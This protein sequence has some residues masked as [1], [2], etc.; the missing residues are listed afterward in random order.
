MRGVKGIIIAAGAAFGFTAQ[1]AAAQ[2][3]SQQS[4]DAKVDEEK[5]LVAALRQLKALRDARVTLENTLGLAPAPK[6]VDDPQGQ[7]RNAS[8]EAPPS[9]TENKSPSFDT[10]L[11]GI[12][13]GAGIAFTYDL[14]KRDRVRSASLVNGIVRV[15]EVDNVRARLVLESH[16]FFLPRSTFLGIKPDDWGIGPFIALQ[17]G[18]SNIIEGIG[19]GLMLGLKRVRS[20]PDSAAGEKASADTTADGSSFNLGIGVF[21][22]LGVQTLGEGIRANQ[23]LPEGETEIRFSKRSQ[24]GFAILSS[25]AF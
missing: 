23:P 16:Y 18:S 20:N 24:S 2:G 21:Y 1:G 13:F 17:G 11:G 15:D 3:A 6:A 12:K 25:F 8:R 19:A 9:K 7:A 10:S 14:G 5:A 4:I 22:D